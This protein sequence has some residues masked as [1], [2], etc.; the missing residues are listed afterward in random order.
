MKTIGLLTLAW[1]ACES[2]SRAA[3]WPTYR[4]DAERS[5]YTAE[6]I[7]GSPSLAWSFEP[8]HAPEPA[9]PRD[10]RMT[11]D[12]AA[13]VVVAGDLVVFGSSADGRVVALDAKTGQKRW[14]FF[15]GA[16]VRFAPTFVG[17]DLYVA[18]D[19]GYLYCLAAA[20]GSLQAKWRPGPSDAMI[21]G[22]GKMVSRWMARGGPVVR[23]GVVYFAAGI[24]QS[25]GVFLT[26]IDAA[27]RK[28]LWQNEEAG[29]IYM[30]Q[31]HG[32]AMAES[33]ISPQ[34]YLV[35]TA[36][37]LLVP[38]GRAVPAAMN[39]A[40]G[41]FLYYHLQANGKAGGTEALAA[42]GRFYNGG[43]AFNTDDGLI[44]EKL[45]AGSYAAMPGAIV[46]GTP[47]GLQVLTVS[48]KTAP[49]RKGAPVKT[50]KHETAWSLSG[51]DAGAAVIVA[52]DLIV[53]GGAT[54]VTAV[55]VNTKQVAW[56]KTIDGAARGLAVAGGRLYVS[57]TRG[58]IYSFASGETAGT[59]PPSVRE[60]APPAKFRETL[61]PSMSAVAADEIIR[62]TGVKEGFCLD[63]ECTD[64]ELPLALAARTNLQI[65]A[66]C[67]TE[68]EVAAVRKKLAAAGVYGKRV[69]VH[70]GTL[71]NNP[72]GKYFADLVISSHSLD[73]GPLRFDEASPPRVL[74]P[75]GGAFCTGRPG[76]MNHFCRGAL[77]KS[78]SW[79]HQYS[80]LGNSSC[81]TDEL[82]RGQLHALWFRDVD[83]EMP[84]RHGRGPAPVYDRG[85]MFVEG[86]DALRAV[87]AYNGRSLWEF[88]LPGILA[89]YSADHLSGAAVTGSNLCVM[90]DDVYVHDKEH[91]YRLDAATGRTLG[92]FA[93]PQNRDGTPGRWGYLAC[94]GELLYGTLANPE[95]VVRFGWRRADMNDLWSES[96]AFFALDAK[97]GALRWRY[98]AADSIRHNAIAIGDDTVYLIDRKVAEED[99]LDPKN[100]DAKLPAVA[101]VN[102]P[103]GS[104]LAIDKL[105]GEARWKQPGA[106]G[107]MLVYSREHDALLMGYQSTRFKIPSEVG[108]R[109]AVYRG[110]SGEPLWNKEA[111]YVTRPFINDDAVYAQGGAWELL[112][113][114]ERPFEFTRSYG[115]GQISAS[116]NLMLFRSATL[117]YRSISPDSK[118]ENFGGIR[119]GCWINALPVGG[120]VLVPDASAGCT[121]S[122]QNRSWMALEGDD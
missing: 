70:Q 19:D 115:C 55:D 97:T 99:K 85:R 112:T 106:F 119:P 36:D 53:C 59:A 24:W 43:N 81:S 118:S 28:Q 39:R 34:G 96:T 45:K 27:T 2:S 9:W 90:G 63:L 6:R 111:K 22:N 26:A 23:D 7:A 101:K 104:L 71:E 88:P 73:V 56:T 68:E 51:V 121:C 44:A 64:G 83:L 46:C 62:R 1:L 100:T 92:T 77:A 3:D 47:T 84:Q 76:Q 78:G 4:N 110:R 11:F 13:E 107:T 49:D 87:D 116:K 66:L 21:L 74:R 20:D 57:S 105:T 94:D 8:F 113:G 93:P 14:T 18:S 61:P 48:E 82:V 75:F 117:G 25:D 30:A 35:A 72:Y 95:H 120:L 109:L 69:T 42:G 89:H 65:Y 17:Q 15:T 16:P 114:V 122:Y 29:R 86:V 41:K 108:G 37:K 103:A 79:T 12:L 38:T 31:P 52:G 54:T 80:D 58:T 67:S 50:V 98:D 91:C 40:D 60:T 5:G 10:N 102:Q 33:G 32:G